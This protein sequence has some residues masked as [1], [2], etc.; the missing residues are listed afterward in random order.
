MRSG[1][2]MSCF[3]LSTSLRRSVAVLAAV[4]TLLLVGG[5]PGGC[6][7]GGG[8]S[9]AAVLSLPWS[10]F[11]HDASGS[12]ATGAYLSSN[13]GTIVFSINAPG[14]TTGS[15]AAVGVNDTIYLG[16]GT[17]L[18][19]LSKDGVRSR[20]VEG[21]TAD[22]STPCTPPADGCRPLGQVRS[23]PVV[24]L[25]GDIVVQGQDGAVFALHDD[26]SELSCRWVSSVMGGEAGEDAWSSPVVLTDSEDGSL[27]AVF[28]G[29]ATGHLLALNGDG[30]ERWRALLTE[31]V[32]TAVTASPVISGGMLYI[33]SPDGLLHAFLLGGGRRWQFPVGPAWGGGRPASSPAASVALYTVSHE[34]T[35]VAVNPDG[36]LRWRYRLATS[37]AGSPGVTSQFVP[38]RSTPT[39]VVTPTSDAGSENTPTPTPTPV[40]FID[41]VVYVV[42]EEG[43]VYGIRDSSGALEGSVATGARGV[44]GS[45]TLASNSGDGSPIY[46][47]V[48]FGD[49]E[50]FVY[51]TTLRG[52]PPCAECE[53]SHWEPVPGGGARVGL[54]TAV[55]GSPVIGRDGTIYVT[56]AD[57]LLYA[58]GAPPT[59]AEPT[60]TATP[61]RTPSAGPGST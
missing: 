43:T 33:A 16:T 20:L 48:V 39:P 18:W 15:S 44:E 31:S 7:G 5:G 42:D 54:G 52:E 23:S 40:T 45:P 28:V 35:V 29:T 4:W 21:C 46:P 49:A 30:T 11:R 55:V 2:G 50:G 61:Q 24:T 14:G 32:G 47:F 56:T 26:G 8:G 58:I 12:G 59:E 38:I 41:T 13:P 53:E 10:R 6:S 36:T 1:A 34:G 60:A 37:V 25:D 22:A 17:G 19:S 57:G 51:A 9:S 3:G 27:S